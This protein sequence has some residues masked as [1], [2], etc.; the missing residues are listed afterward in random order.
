MPTQPIRRHF[1]RRFRPL[2]LAALWC[3][4]P[5]AGGLVA[6]TAEAPA[7]ETGP[8]QK[9][10]NDLTPLN[11]FTVEGSYVGASSFRIRRFDGDGPLNT[12]Q[13]YG[14]QDEVQAHVEYAHR[15]HLVDRVYLKLGGT[16][17]RFDFGGTNAPLPTSLQSISG[18]IAVEYVVRRRPAAFITTSPGVYFSDFDDIS[19]GNFDAPTALGTIVPVNKKFFL[20]LGVRASLLA[21]IPVFPIAGAVWL[22]NDRMR[23][24]AIPP[25]PR[26]IVEATSKLNVFAGAELLGNAYKRDET[27]YTQRGEKRFS[28]GVI[29]YSEVRGGGGFSYAFTKLVVLDVTGGW[30]FGRNFNYYRSAGKR[31]ITE[32][33]PYAKV[34]F[35]ADF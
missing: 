30:D 11:S 20:L 6:G 31:F 1:S 26:L 27:R 24:E 19:T 35:T 29:D 2:L 33:A 4:L 32:G 12:Q 22:I 3:V 8:T 28:G 25:E 34:K 5:S 16:Y 13:S 9:I 18:R 14:R 17:E 7:P 23:L 21:R 10:L 15:F